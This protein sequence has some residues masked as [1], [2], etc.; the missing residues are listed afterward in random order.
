[1]YFLLIEEVCMKKHW[2]IIT[3]ILLF[4]VTVTFIGARPVAATPVPQGTVPGNVYLPIVSTGPCTVEAQPRSKNVFGVQM[5]GNTSVDSRYFQE[6][7]DSQTS[8]V[9]DEVVWSSV[10][11][12]NVSPSEYRW[13]TVDK[14]LSAAIEGGINMIGTINYNPAWAAASAIGPI[15]PENLDDFAEFLTALVERY[16]GDGVDD[17]P[18]GRVVKYW[19][20]YNE[21]DGH[22]DRWGYDGDKYAQMLSVA[23]PAMK[24]ADP[25]AQIVFGGIAYDWFDD[26]GGPFVRRFLT[27]VLNAGGGAYFD[28]MNFHVYPAFAPNW[29][30]TGPGLYEKAKAIRQVLAG[31]GLDKPMMITES[32]AHSNNDPNAPST[33]QIQASYVIE[34]FTQAK[35]VNIDAMIWFA[36]YDP[37]EWYPQKNGLVT[38]ETPPQRKLAFS[39]FQLAVD[40]IA[41]ASFDRVLS[42]GEMG[43]NDMQAYRVTQ[44]G[45]NAPL[46]VAWMAPVTT[47]RTATLSVPGQQATVYDIYSNARTVR[48]SDDG[49]SDGRIS[50]QIGREPI[51]IEVN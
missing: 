36:L 34:L 6:M 49:S 4:V 51:L 7:I 12:Q 47:D 5:Y 20:F 26:Q 31:Y 9:R 40:K 2:F 41:D 16:D 19:E 50:V 37:P 44:S 8:W 25:E 14:A 15:N 48:D 1:M 13:G 27:D 35:A 24:A 17:D 46:Y 32:G 33:P 42:A 18:C 30:T 22:A 28:V 11:P 10:E 45:S 38:A 29:T 39:T 43:D 23:Y 3:V 21:P